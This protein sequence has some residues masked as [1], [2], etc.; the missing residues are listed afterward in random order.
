MVG[1]DGEQELTRAREIYDGAIHSGN[2]V[3]SLNFLKLAPLRLPIFV[4]ILSTKPPSHPL[5]NSKKPCK[6]S[7]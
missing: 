7:T 4:K 1:S 2:S 5:M 3:A 6:I